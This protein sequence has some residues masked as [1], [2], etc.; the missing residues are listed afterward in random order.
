M[1]SYEELTALVGRDIRNG[2][3]SNLGTARRFV[4]REHQIVFDVVPNV[5]LR[6]M[7]DEE[8]VGSADRD[9]RHMSKTTRKT[10]HRLTCVKFAELPREQQVEHNAKLS[11]LGV[12]GMMARPASVQTVQK[13]IASQGDAETLATAKT[14]DLLK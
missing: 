3:Y 5:G 8:I 7:T 1:V 11:V 10:A 12:M 6:R 2:A 9:L 4:Q 13:A 14:M